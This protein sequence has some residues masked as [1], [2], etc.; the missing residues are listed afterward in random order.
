M[1]EPAWKRPFASGED[2]EQLRFA[3]T[4][5]GDWIEVYDA[6]T[7]ERLRSPLEEEEGRK[8]AEERASRAE[9]E[10]ERLRAE[11]EKLKGR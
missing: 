9:A 7:G 1:A 4:A 11:I 8:A 3:V 5:E 6:R 10:L 2:R